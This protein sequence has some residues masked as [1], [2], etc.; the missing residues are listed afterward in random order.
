MSPDRLTIRN[1]N[2]SPILRL[3]ERINLPGF[4]V[5]CLAIAVWEIYCRTI[6]SHF[7]SIAPSSAIFRAILDLLLHGPL[8]GQL[9]HTVSVALLGWIIASGLG[10]VIG[11]LL[12]ISRPAWIYTMASI[13]VLR[14]IPSISFVSIALLIFGF[15]SSAEMVIVV[16]VSLWPVLLGT[17]GGIRMVPTSLR[18]IARS[19]RMSWSATTFK[20]VL[21]AALPSIIIGLRLALTLSVALAVVAEM[22]GNPQGLGFGMVF[23]EQAMQPAQAFAYLA[24][25]GILGWTL[26]A[27]FVIATHYVARGHPSL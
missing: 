7:E 19:L 9:A 26:N 27:I 2:E 21:P 22:V 23:S 6:G 14:S 10:F 18:D 13:D 16:Y 1:E 25:I 12:A 8:L 11:L 17:L 15:S 5:I 20:V 24:V 3:F 4:A